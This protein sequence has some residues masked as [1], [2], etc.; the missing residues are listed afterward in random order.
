MKKIDRYFERCIED[1]HKAEE[2]E[3]KSERVRWFYI[4]VDNQILFSINTPYAR[5]SRKAACRIR[6]N[7]KKNF[8]FDIDG[9]Y[10]IDTILQP[11]FVC[12][13]FMVGKDN[14][15]L[16]EKMDDNV[17][18]GEVIGS[19]RYER[20]CKAYYKVTTDEFRERHDELHLPSDINWNDYRETYLKAFGE[21]PE[22]E[23]KEQSKTVE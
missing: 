4:V 15:Y 6:N 21:Y 16:C 20:L 12:N 5:V 1:A 14:M 19:G 18:K 11:N 23:I 8:G 3:Y 2:R 17:E 22:V 9:D 7:I 13:H 10:F